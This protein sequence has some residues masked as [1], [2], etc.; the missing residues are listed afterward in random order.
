MVSASW[1]L[2]VIRTVWL[3]LSFL[4]VL[5]GAASFRFAFGHF[6]AANASSIARS[7]HEHTVATVTK[8]DR[9]RA[10]KISPAIVKSSNIDQG[11]A[12]SISSTSLMIVPP[13]GQDRHPVSPKVREARSDRSKR[14]PARSQAIAEKSRGTEEAKPC[15]LMDF[16]AFRWALGMPTGCHI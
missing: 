15:Q 7:D 13:S 16:D 9:L 10:E 14:K 8:A 1:G 11:Q 2:N 5:A 4:V 6:D 3:G 12:G